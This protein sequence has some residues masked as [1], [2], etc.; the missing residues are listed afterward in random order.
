[1]LWLLQRGVGGRLCGDVRSLGICAQNPAEVTISPARGVAFYCSRVLSC[2]GQSLGAG[3][4]LF[5][6]PI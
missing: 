6:T 4:P 2:L 5:L 1:M 3:R